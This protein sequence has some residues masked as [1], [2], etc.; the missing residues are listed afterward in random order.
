MP[1]R[2]PNLRKSTVDIESDVKRPVAS[3]PARRGRQAAPSYQ[4]LAALYDEFFL[5]FQETMEKARSAALG[6]ILPQVKTACDLGS[7][8]GS[9]ALRLAQ[10]GMKVYAVDLSPSMCRA[11]RRKVREAKAKVQVIQADMRGF[12]LSHPVDLILCEGD[13]LNHVPRKSDLRRVARA[14]FRALRPGGWFFFD[15]NNRAGFLRYW[16]GT[17]CFEK[18]SS[19]M[20]MRSAHSRD[21]QRA[22]A[23]IDLFIRYR[24][25]WQRHRERV[26]EVC[27]SAAEIRRVFRAAGF[28]RMRAWDAAPFFGPKSVVTPGCRSFYLVHKPA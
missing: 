16:T 12:R 3:P 28:D 14:A 24:G 25:T 27:W 17:V 21:G 8:T 15:V 13:A 11:A 2:K 26:E 1:S 10:Q 23:D 4:R 19:V 22:S 5:P 9:T 20:V 6:S 7:G 18:P